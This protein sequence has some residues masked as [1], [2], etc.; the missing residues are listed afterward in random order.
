[1]LGLTLARMPWHICCS[2]GIST[3]AW[4]VVARRRATAESVETRVKGDAKG[5]A[6]KLYRWWQQQVLRDVVR[7]AKVRCPS[8]GRGSNY[9]NS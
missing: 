7:V 4:L 5:D 6:K 3:A 8:Q 9:D 1:M 2:L